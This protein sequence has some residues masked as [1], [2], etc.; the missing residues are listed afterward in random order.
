M[1]REAGLCCGVSVVMASRPAPG[2]HDAS[3]TLAVKLSSATRLSLLSSQPKPIR[4]LPL[5]WVCATAVRRP[6]AMVTSS[7][8]T[9]SSPSSEWSLTLTWTARKLPSGPKAALAAE[10]A[11]GSS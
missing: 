3:C 2:C 10:L 8:C 11:S 6:L 4:A 9:A 5:T 1:T 7:S